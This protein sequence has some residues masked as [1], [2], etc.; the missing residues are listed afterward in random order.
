MILHLGLLGFVTALALFIVALRP[1]YRKHRPWGYVLLA[2][3]PLLVLAVLTRFLLSAPG[4]PVI[5]WLLPLTGVLVVGFYCKSNK[6]FAAYSASALIISLVLCGNYIALVHGGGY[7]GRPS[8]SE[9][10]WRNSELNAVRS[11]ESDLRKTFPEEAIVPEGPVATLVGN[12]EYN[13]VEKI[14]ARRTWH[15]WLTGLYAI[16]RRD[17]VVWCRGGEPEALS[18]RIEIR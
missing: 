18:S 11:A 17:A 6:L 8:V 14:H 13:H 16:E 10:G 5:E 2:A 15:T 9:H 12:E 1:G 4:V 3:A 7:T